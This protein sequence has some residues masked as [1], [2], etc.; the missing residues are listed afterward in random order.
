MNTQ[1]ACGTAPGLPALFQHIQK[2]QD[3][4]CNLCGVIEAVH[5]LDNGKVAP[6]A[7]TALLNVALMMAADL[8]RN[9]DLVSLPKGGDA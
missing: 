1:P 7:V 3:L 4:A 2:Q 6:D 5:I 9:L 8:N